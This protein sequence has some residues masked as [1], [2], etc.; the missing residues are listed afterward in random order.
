LGSDLNRLSGVLTL[1]VNL[2]YL[3]SHPLQEAQRKRS[4]LKKPSPVSTD[5]RVRYFSETERHRLFM[6]LNARDKLII[7]GRASHNEHRERRGKCRLPEITGYGDFLHPLVVVALNTGLRRGELLSLT[8][9]DIDLHL[10]QIK[11][12][13]INTK[14]G[15]P[16]IIPLNP[17]A[18][19]ALRRWKSQSCK[20]V[21]FTRSGKKMTHFK[22]SWQGLLDLAQIKN[23]RFHDCRHDFA[24]QLVMAG[25]DLYTVS[26]L[27]GHTSIDTTQRYA[28]L[29]PDHLR[30]AVNVLGNQH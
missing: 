2:D 19:S 23:F 10:N 9:N 1:A 8:W 24:S 25:T 22:R 14:T 17:D 16:R 15:R 13:S 28:H 5:I 20:T 27:L 12:R 18:A 7:K 6:A 11:V 26:Q 30:S 29:S 4:G 21:V 3:E